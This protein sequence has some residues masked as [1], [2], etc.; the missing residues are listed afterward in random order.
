MSLDGSQPQIEW[1]ESAVLKSFSSRAESRARQILQSTSAR[2]ALSTILFANFVII[3]LETDRAAEN[4]PPSPTLSWLGRLCLLCFVLELFI[5]FLGDRKAFFQSQGYYFDMA[6]VGVDVIAEVLNT[7]AAK[8]PH[9]SWLRV[10]KLLKLARLIRTVRLLR[11]LSFMVRGLAGAMR[12]IFWAGVLLFFM[13]TFWSI[14]AVQVLQP[15]NEKVAETGAYDGCSQCPRAFK[16]VMEA[17]LTFFQQLVAGDA[18][19]QV[20]APIILMFP[21]TAALFGL[22][23][24]SINLGVLNLIL[25]CIVD[26]ATQFREQDTELQ[27]QRNKEEFQAKCKEL[28]TSFEAMDNDGSGNLSLQEILEGFEHNHDFARTLHVMGIQKHDLEVLFSMMDTDGSGQVG[29]KEFVKGVYQVQRSNLQTDMALVKHHITGVQKEFWDLRSELKEMYRSTLEPSHASQNVKKSLFSPASTTASN[30]HTNIL[31]LSAQTNGSG[32]L[33]KDA[34]MRDLV[35]VVDQVASSIETFFASL[36]DEMQH[37]TVR[38]ELL[39][40]AAPSLQRCAAACTHA[41][42]NG[43]C[44]L[45]RENIVQGKEAPDISR[46]LV[47]QSDARASG[48]HHCKSPAACTKYAEYTEYTC[49]SV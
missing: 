26:Q 37:E 43:S 7:T 29:Y 39:L 16:T 30:S 8:L 38:L 10:L 24:L 12:A 9:V 6:L 4:L 3:I 23:L 2:C 5:A 21:W 44:D 15:L 14:V 35:A 11:E 45:V 46:T 31:E 1:T 13:L 36:K 19:G 33:T 49:V 27:I 22:I 17:N 25:T 48:C 18:W 20:S 47:V 42:C 34:A 32:N 40:N 41:S 28:L